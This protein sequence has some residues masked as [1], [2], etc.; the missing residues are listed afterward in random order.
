MS[1]EPINPY[2]EDASEVYPEGTV[3][4]SQNMSSASFRAVSHILAKYSFVFLS[5]LLAECALLEWLTARNDADDIFYEEDH[6]Y[7]PVDMSGEP[8]NPYNEVRMVLFVKYVICVISCRQPY[9]SKVFFRIFIITISRPINPYNEDASEVY[10]E[11]TVVLSPSVTALGHITFKDNNDG[12][13][14]FYDVPSHFQDHR[15]TEDII[16]FRLSRR[17]RCNVTCYFFNI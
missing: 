16:M 5:L 15:W 11:G 1:G 8:I 6:T 7:E 4:L 17:I 10:P 3:V 14:T 2:N 9:F 13:V 12:T